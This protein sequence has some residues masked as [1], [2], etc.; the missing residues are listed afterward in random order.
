MASRL[1][2]SC[3][4][5]SAPKRSGRGEASQGGVEEDLERARGLFEKACEAG[6][7]LGCAQLESLEAGATP[8]GEE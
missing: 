7:A 5:V 3:A 8:P 1:S 2:S 6:N 4:G